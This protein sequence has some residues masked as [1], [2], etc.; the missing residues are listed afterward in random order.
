[1]LDAAEQCRLFDE[2]ESISP[3][4]RPFDIRLDALAIEGL[5]I[6]DLL[7]N[8]QQQSRLEWWQAGPF[9]DLAAV[10]HHALLLYHCRNFTYYS[11]WITR[12]VPQLHQAE[13]DKHVAAILDLSQRLLSD[14]YVPAVL[15]LFPLRMAGAYVSEIN[16]QNKVL[17]SLREI[18]RKG[19]IVSDEI[20]VDLRQLW[21]E[22][23]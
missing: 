16:A 3:E 22:D 15:L 6:K 5:E 18:R 12:A 17:G 4:S 23:N 13:V 8:W 2:I 21:Q 10:V 1:M 7:L 19:F 20:E 11:C 14:T 9:N